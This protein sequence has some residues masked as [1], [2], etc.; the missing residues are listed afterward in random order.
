MLSI[1]NF[2]IVLLLT[3]A[4]GLSSWSIYVSK[5]VKPKVITAD[6][7]PD[8]FME[9]VIATIINKDGK[10]SLVIK[11]PKMVHYPKDDTVKITS[12]EITLYRDSPEPWYI[13]ANHATATHGAKEIFFW[14]N[15]V[16][17]H[18]KDKSA[19][20]TTFLTDTLTVIP[21]RHIAKTK[22]D[23]TLKQPDTTVHAKG[24]KANWNNGEIKL[25]ST[26]RGVYAP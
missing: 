12:P 25:L 26:T 7:L 5:K 10:P 9:N 16:I 1:K 23:I 4:C 3:V 17:N 22:D 2:F 21:K 18:N 24:M 20:I 13:N 11:S 19:P 8:S 6:T 15:V 14:S